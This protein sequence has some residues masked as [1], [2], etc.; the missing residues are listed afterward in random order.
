MSNNSYSPAS[1]RYTNSVGYQTCGKSG[2]QLPR[3]SLGL[4]HNFGDVDDAEEAL[5]M[6][7]F[8]FDHG[9]THF[10]LANNYG[11]PFGSAEKNFGKIL[12]E[13]F[14]AHRDE[15]IISTKAGHEMW[16]GPYG[17]GGS[18]KY[19]IASI[20]QSLKRMELDYVDIFYSHR[21]DPNTPLEE[22]MCALSD[23]VKQGKA[24]YIGI[25]K[26]PTEVAREAYRI[27]RE[28]GTPCLINQDRYSIFT[29]QI[30]QSVLPLAEENGVG[31]IGFSPLAQGMLSDKYLKGIPENSRAAHSYGFLQ[32]SQL[33]PERIEKITKLNDI[34]AQRG[35]TLAQM[36]LAWCLHKPQVTSVI[37]GTSSVKQLQDN[38][39]SLKNTTFTDDELWR[40]GELG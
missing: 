40:I 5:K 19:L 12:K 39:D 33:T 24:L 36:A 38:I 28:N 9:I 32:K 13:N 23:M 3:I 11:T 17:D 7:Q 27:L 37:V 30:E 4:W 22:T 14:A 34:A 21:Y 35:Q 1:D 31:F 2:L 8:A 10:D 29:R 16:A 6:I 26:Y 25:S 15:M 20:N 18:R